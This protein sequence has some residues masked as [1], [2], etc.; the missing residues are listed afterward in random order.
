MR[1]SFV[2]VHSITAPYRVHLFQALHEEL[3][4]RDV[5]F[6][7]HFMT[8]RIG[9]RPADW[10]RSPGELS[11][12][13]TFWRATGPTYRGRQRY[14][15]PGML[16]ALARRRADVLMVGGLWD[17]MTGALASLFARRTLGIGWLEV[18]THS[19]GRLD[20]VY[21]WSKRALI[22]RFDV[23]AVPGEEGRRYV[24][25]LFDGGGGPRVEVLPNVV[26]EA[27]F[28]AGEPDAVERQRA[29]V[30]AELGLG[31][32][33]RLALWPARLIPDKGVVPF[34]ENIGPRD[35][36]GWRLV[37]LGDGP[38]H[39]EVRRVLATRGLEGSVTV[40]GGVEYARM[41]AFYHAADLLVLPSLRDANP[42]SVV[43]ALHAGL[44]ILVSRRVGNIH[45]ALEEGVNGWSLDPADPE[46]VRSTARRAFG[47]E[48]ARLRTMG[49]ASRRIA[50]AHW[51]TGAAVGRFLDAIQLVRA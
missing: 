22:G 34:L 8:R 29:E 3:A 1:G 39:A 25:D 40:H 21:G 50:R 20:G 23:I 26:D 18:N 44:P 49:E 27:R 7:V 41:P 38:L 10:E 13:H 5:A 4:R 14:L 11:F 46:S 16:A 47:S 51:D 28:R 24:A 19:P 31:A 36:D 6:H 43:E 9:H 32:D 30:R 17:S 15:N 35:L 45:E 37:I 12:P 42:L 48:P 33:E 2:V